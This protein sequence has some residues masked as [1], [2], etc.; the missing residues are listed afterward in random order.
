M[1]ERRRSSKPT[2]KRSRTIKPAGD[3]RKRVKTVS[4]PVE[5][6]DNGHSSR[7]SPVVKEKD[8][9]DDEVNAS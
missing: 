6:S 3:A 2:K 8:D 5:E 9:Q 7:A 4:S 1:P